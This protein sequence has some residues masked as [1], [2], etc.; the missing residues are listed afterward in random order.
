MRKK[1]LVDFHSW[2]QTRIPYKFL[3]DALQDVEDAQ[4][5]AYHS[6]R[7]RSTLESLRADLLFRF[8]KEKSEA[9]TF[10]RDDLGASRLLSVRFPVWNVRN[11]KSRL[12]SF[13]TAIESPRDL[14]TFC[15]EGILVGDLIYDAFCTHYSVSSPSINDP[16]L[17]SFVQEAIAVV[18]FWL[19]FFEK[20]YVTAIIGDS[21]YLQGIPL[22]VAWSRGVRAYVGNLNGLEKLDSANPYEDSLFRHYP[23]LSSHIPPKVLKYGLRQAENSLSDLLSGKSVR[24]KNLY[25]GP[26]AFAQ[27]GEIEMEFD[28]QKESVLIVPHDFFDSSH[29]R[30]PHLYPDFRLWLWEIGRLSR[31]IAVN[32]FLKP[33]PRESDR[34]LEVLREFG[35]EFD[36]IR[37]LP[38]DIN[39][40]NL[41][42]LNVKTALTVKGTIAGEYPL[43]GIR[44]INASLANFHVRYTFADSPDNLD[45]YECMLRELASGSPAPSTEGIYEFFYLRHIFEHEGTFLNPEEVQSL[46][47][48]SPMDSTK[49][50]GH[51]DTGRTEKM[52]Q[53]VSKFV[54]DNAHWLRGELLI[55]LQEGLLRTTNPMGKD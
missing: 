3:L 12:D 8:G 10:Y 16:N 13:P 52:R 17:H 39:P 18:D 43:L 33:H 9:A 55:R 20:N 49:L 47:W 6:V 48:L 32:W 11:R 51:Y 45:A 46:D 14:E 50:W 7:A 21:V 28:N 25:D 1:I 30:G 27:R 4:V 5:V 42:E 44:V 53:L 41:I 23:E 26:S 29:M 24:R 38:G 36:H 31:E 15:V 54:S 37:F 2:A 35:A 19:N 40:A 22:R 34:T